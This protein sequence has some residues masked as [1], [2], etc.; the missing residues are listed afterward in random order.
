MPLVGY[1]NDAGDKVTFEECWKRESFGGLPVEILYRIYLTNQSEVRPNGLTVTNLL[2]CSRKA[3][4]QRREPYYDKPRFLYALFR[5]TIL[6]SVLEDTNRLYEKGHI[7]SEKRYHRMVPGTN[8]DLSGKIDKYNRQTKTLEDYKTTMDD[9]VSELIRR[10]PEDYIKQANIYRWIMEANGL[11]VEQIK[12][13]FFG[14]KFAYTSGEVSLVDPAWTRPRWERLAA[15]PVLTLP[16]IEDFVVHRVKD[17]LRSEMPPV[18]G[19]D[20]R[21]MC[22]GCPFAKTVCWPGGIP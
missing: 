8:V 3:Y 12:I 6:H 2:G 10:M 1:E 4:L 20:Q 13:H 7:V 11:P 15:C 19:P 14:W 16:Q 5:G 22:R 17:I 18:V 21:W 9:K